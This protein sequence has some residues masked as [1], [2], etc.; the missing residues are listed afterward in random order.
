MA[1]EISI[2]A[3]VQSASKMIEASH[4]FVLVLCISTTDFMLFYVNLS[5]PDCKILEG[6]IKV[7]FLFHYC[8]YLKFLDCSC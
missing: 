6:G 3:D 5:E 1:Q 4:S 2:S 7:A 8:C